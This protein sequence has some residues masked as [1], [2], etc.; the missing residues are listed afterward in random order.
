MYSFSLCAWSL[1]NNINEF[2]ILGEK[3]FQCE[4]C[5]QKFTAKAGL[6]YHERSQ[7]QSE[8]QTC[9]TC[10][11]FTT[12]FKCALKCHMESVHNQYCWNVYIQKI[13][14]LLPYFIGIELFP[15]Q[16]SMLLFVKI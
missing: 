2:I 16:I 7:K 10:S 15:V 4:H 8:L 13:L 12:N 1:T 11:T 5:K 3:P 9:Q 14:S 6:N